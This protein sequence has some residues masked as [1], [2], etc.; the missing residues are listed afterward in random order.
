M[1]K[2]FSIFS[3][4]ILFFTGGQTFLLFSQN[5]SP[6]NLTYLKL[7]PEGKIREY[8]ENNP[9]GYLAGSLNL[10]IWSAEKRK[11]CSSM[12]VAERL[13]FENVREMEANR[14]AAIE[15]WPKKDTSWLY[16]KN[17][18][19]NFYEG[20]D[21]GHL[22]EVASCIVKGEPL[23]P[24]QKYQELAKIINKFIDFGKNFEKAKK[25][26]EKGKKSIEQDGESAK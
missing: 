25:I 24:E 10:L 8:C 19:G 26:S 6:E 23:S 9:S 4:I 12:T 5:P 15:G 11:E 13:A 16:K 17:D 7:L 22:R 3:L 14:V 2:S 21:F 20:D 18:F 1:N